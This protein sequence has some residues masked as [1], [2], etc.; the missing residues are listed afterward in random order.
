VRY[1]C[2]II[3]L[4]DRSVIDGITAHNINQLYLKNDQIC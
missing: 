1:N 3:D 2:S 4:Y